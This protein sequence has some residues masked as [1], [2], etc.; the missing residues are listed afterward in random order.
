MRL[1]RPLCHLAEVSR[2]K[3]QSSRTW[4]RLRPT[5]RP[6]CRAGQRIQLPC[7]VR[8]RDLSCR[9]TGDRCAVYTRHPY[10]A[11]HARLGASWRA[12]AAGRR[13]TRVA[14]AQCRS[15]LPEL[16]RMRRAG[17]GARHSSPPFWQAAGDA[18]APKKGI[19]E[20]SRV[21]LNA[22]KPPLLDGIRPQLLAVQ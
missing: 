7:V 4:A 16:C 20:R 21:R 18:A 9:S 3:A 10:G 6:P 8:V 19:F 17:L 15:S 14:R 2:L 22:P 1:V 13:S 12:C 11:N 5:P